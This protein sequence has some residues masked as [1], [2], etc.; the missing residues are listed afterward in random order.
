MGDT[1][2]SARYCQVGESH[3]NI[4][5]SMMRR[6]PISWGR[7]GFEAL[8]LTTPFNPSTFYASENFGNCLSFPGSREE[9][10][11]LRI[12]AYRWWEARAGSRPS[13]G[14]A[15]LARLRNREVG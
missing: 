4:V 2:A 15:P 12:I 5:G 11:L 7:I 13:G 10:D 14:W 8:N 6:Q 9:G 3:H 1:N